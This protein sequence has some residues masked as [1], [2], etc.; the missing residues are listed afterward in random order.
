MSNILISV[1]ERCY[2]TASTLILMAG[3]Q[4]GQSQGKR[5]KGRKLSISASLCPSGNPH[6]SGCNLPFPVRTCLNVRW[7]CYAWGAV[8]WV[9]LCQPRITCLFTWRVR[10]FCFYT[11]HQLFFLLFVICLKAS[12]FPGFRVWDLLRGVLKPAYQLDVFFLLY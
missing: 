7:P 9:A 10:L 8:F 4:A 12:L 5:G 11:L 1:N 6:S 2:G 3:Q